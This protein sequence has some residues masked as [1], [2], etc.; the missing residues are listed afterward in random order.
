MEDILSEQNALEFDQEEVH[1]L[2]KVLE[3]SLNGLLGDSVVTAGAE[4][5]GDSPLENNMAGN[6]DG[7]SHCT[8][9]LTD[10]SVD[11]RSRDQLTSQ[12]HVQ[13]LKGPAEE[14]QITG[15]E[16]E[17]DHAGVGNGGRTGLFPLYTHKREISKLSK[18]KTRTTTHTQKA[19]HQRVVG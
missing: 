16:D 18:L 2:L 9:L 14:R 15:G 19:I 5:T 12:R 7:S 11:R 4:S 17:T 8:Q 13:E 1:K 3:N 6:F 10:H